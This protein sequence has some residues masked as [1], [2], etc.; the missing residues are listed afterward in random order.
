MPGLAIAEGRGSGGGTAAEEQRVQSL[1]ECLSIK[2]AHI[3]MPDLRCD[4]TQPLLKAG[5][6]LGRI[7]WSCRHFVR[8]KAVDPRFSLLQHCFKCSCAFGLDQIVRVLSGR[9]CRKGQA[10]SRP[11]P[12]KG[13][14]G[15][16]Y[17]PPLP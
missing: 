10:V 12:G 2:R 5:A 17:P 1:P 11:Q 4:L 6:L 8:P 14:H 9:Q 7:E 3:L 15:P 13:P 16:A